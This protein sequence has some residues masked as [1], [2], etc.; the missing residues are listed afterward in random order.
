MGYSETRE[1]EEL[2]G[3]IELLEREQAE[4]TQQLCSP[5]IYCDRPDEA[6]TLQERSF[7]IEEELMGRL[8]RWEEL[9]AKSNAE[10]DRKYS[11]KFPKTLLV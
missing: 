4:I 10:A 3:R 7:A 1:L 2:P 8:L 6:R 11:S 9:E 5:E